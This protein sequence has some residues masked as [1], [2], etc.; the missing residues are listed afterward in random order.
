M[1]KYPN[2]DKYSNKKLKQPNIEVKPFSEDQLHLNQFFK[3]S[4]LYV[5]SSE[6]I[7]NSLQI[8]LKGSASCG[9]CP[10]CGSISH[11]VHSVYIRKLIDLPVFGKNVSIRFG[12]RKFF[13]KN[14]FCSKK[15]FAEQPGDEICRYRR[16]TKRCETTIG[17]LGIRMSAISTSLILKS[18][19]IPISPS[20][21][22]R[23]IYRIPLPKMGKVTELGV[24]DWAFRKGLVYG[25]ILVDMKKGNVIDL[26]ADRETESFEHWIREHTEV[27]L[28]SRDRSTNYSS[29]IANTEREIVEVADRFHLIKNMADCVT[30]VISE[31]YTDYRSIIRPEE[32]SVVKDE[33]LIVENPSNISVAVNAKTDSR[34][35]MFNEVKELQ[36]KGFKINAIAKKLHIARQAARKYMKYETLP[37]RQSSARNGYYKFDK[38]V[39][40]EYAKG[41]SLLGI[42]KEIQ[43]KGFDGSLTP[44]H[45]HYQYLSQSRIR[46]TVQRKKNSIVQDYRKPLV[47][48]KVISAIVFKNIREYK[49]KEE[50]KSLMDKLMGI[51]WFEYLYNAAESFY[52]IIMG[53]RVDALIQWIEE[54]K[55][56][57]ISKIKTFVTG[58]I[59]DQKA[60]E[61]AIAYPISNGI[62]E[63][64]VNKLKTIKRMMYGRAGLELLKRKMILSNK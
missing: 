32:M 13:C 37:F 42:Y 2:V 39:E 44:F 64:F 14:S 17:D 8:Y 19:N 36:S 62:V 40:E 29:A 5:E 63:G 25:S 38:Y 12:A 3:S 56:T 52:E 58:I 35:N 27:Q 18:M 59:L 24:D 15:T 1:P 51:K 43:K 45:G 9:V 20:T 23:S 4:Q 41:K 34:T 10:Y 49:L 46:K 57:T 47:P 7:D 60:V 54:A 53:N 33:K 48:V 6:T 16:R 28:V 21:A 22:L 31:N 26:L 61:N 30:K 50:E 55:N 11:Q